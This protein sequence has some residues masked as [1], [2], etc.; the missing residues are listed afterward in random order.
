M[1]N[2]GNR[3]ELQRGKFSNLNIEIPDMKSRFLTTLAAFVATS[4][5]AHA[6]ADVVNVSTRGKVGT[7]DDVM[8]IG[9]RR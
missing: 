5:L 8:I 7:G 1:R 4:A 3:P 2:T 9:V 6:A